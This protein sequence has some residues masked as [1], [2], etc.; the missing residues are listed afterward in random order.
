MSLRVFLFLLCLCNT[1]SLWALCAGSTCT[2]SSTSSNFG[3][4]APL[5]GI[6][7]ITTNTIV[8]SCQSALPI[9]SCSLT[10]SLSKGSG[11]YSKRKMGTGGDTLEYNLYTSSSYTTIFGDGTGGSQSQTKSCTSIQNKPPYNCTMSFVVYGKIPG[12]L[13][14]TKTGNY[15]DNITA[16]ANY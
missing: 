4:Y 13:S 2:L 6:Q 14:S 16:T 10:L 15:I 9:S 12:G 11:N 3:S 1:P 7:A 8:A 5:T